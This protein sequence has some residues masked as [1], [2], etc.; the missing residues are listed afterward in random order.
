M[1]GSRS[2]AILSYLAASFGWLVVMAIWAA[3]AGPYADPRCHGPFSFGFLPGAMVVPFAVLIIFAF[4]VVIHAL[5]AFRRKRF[6]G[7]PG[8]ASRVFDA[9]FFVPFAALSTFLLAAVMR[10]DASLHCFVMTAV[11]ALPWLATP[12]LSMRL[13]TWSQR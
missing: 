10:W 2:A 1:P 3:I 12:W 13:V 4:S 6:E 11:L 5:F 9:A 7:T 8:A